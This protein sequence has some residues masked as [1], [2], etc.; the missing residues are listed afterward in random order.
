M[1]ESPIQCAQTHLTLSTQTFFNQLLVFI[2]LNFSQHAQNQAI[3]LFYS[4][5]IVNL[6]ILQFD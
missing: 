4:R 5:D 2:D 6:K 1:L 3:S